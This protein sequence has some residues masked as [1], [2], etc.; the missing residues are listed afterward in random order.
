LGLFISFQENIDT[1]NPLGKAI[2]TIASAVAEP[3][4][5]II[6]II[7]RVRAGLRKAK[8]NGKR[9]GRPKRLDLNVRHTPGHTS[10]LALP[11]TLQSGI[12]LK[13]NNYRLK[14]GKAWG[15][16][17]M[18]SSISI[19]YFSFS[20]PSNERASSIFWRRFSR[21]RRV[22]LISGS[23]GRVVMARIYSRWGR[24]GLPW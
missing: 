16:I 10:S 17:F 6:I 15:R 19:I 8:E 9:L 23:F 20:F 3:E 2:F 12:I 24:A 5:N 4:R 7:V 14:N 21:S 22:F 18:I 11:P 13:V 1:S